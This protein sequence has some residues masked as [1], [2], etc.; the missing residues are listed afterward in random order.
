MKTRKTVLSWGEINMAEL[1]LVKLIS[2]FAQSN[3]AEGKSP[4]TI[5]WYSEM[6]FDFV[7]FLRSTGSS[8]VLAQFHPI[9]ARDFI[10]HEQDRGLSPY[11]V[12]GKVRS[13]KAF[14]SWLFAEGY[15]SENLLANLKLPRV[16]I[17]IIEPLSAEEIDCLLAAQNPLT[18][19]GC[20]DIAILMALLDT[21]SRCSELC[22]LLF[23]DAHIQEGYLKVVG[24]GNKER[25][26]PVGALAQKAISRYIFHFRPEPLKETDDRLFLTLDGKALQ[27][28]AVKLLLK[29]WGRRAGVPRLHAHLCRHTFA[30][31]FLTHKCGDVF[32]LQQILGHSSLQMV[33][34]YVHYASAQDMILGRVSSPLDHLDIK[35]I[36]G[37]KIDRLLKTGSLSA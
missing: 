25:I 31:N 21:G 35:R 29:R 20:R 34:K 13:L 18:H 3:K 10:V 33:G 23:Q 37:H 26:L 19:V 5:S 27:A 2:H 4:K 24:K 22:T 11:T 17:R 28:N 9:S 30:T 36:K 16:P 12:Q 15:T 1:D 32:R 8:A 7:K 6:L 14:G